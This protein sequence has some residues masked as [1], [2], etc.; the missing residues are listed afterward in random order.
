LRD[1]L[2]IEPNN[3]DALYYTGLVQ[4]ARKRPDLAT[5]PL[6][7]ARTLA[8]TDQSITYQLGLA[9][10][11]QERY[12]EAE[13]LLVAIFNANPRADGVGYYVGFMRYRKKNYQGALR[14][15]EAGAT[16]DPNIRQL[17]RF[18]SG[19]ALA[20]L[21]LPERAAAEV[22][23]ARGLLPA[24]P[25]TG[26]AERLRD[27]I[28]A[29]RE[30]ER[31]FHAELRLGFLYD[32]N[33]AVLPE[34]S[35]D[36]TA[37]ALRRRGRKTPGELASARFDYTWLREGP[38][39]LAAGYAFFQTINN[40][41][42]K[43]NVEN[44]LGSLTAGYRGT[45][46]AMPYQLGLGYT[47][48]ILFLDNDEFTQRHSPTASGTLVWDARH[49]SAALGRLQTKEFTHDRH[50]AQEEVRDAVN[51]LVGL[52]HFLR[53]AN[54]RH[55]VRGGYQLDWENADGRNFDYVG[56][57]LLVGGQYTLPWGETRLRYDYDVHFRNY[58]GPHTILP[59]AAPRTRERADTEQTHTFRIEQPLP[60]G[61]TLSA[62]WL[63]S[64]AR[65][66]L[67]IFSYNRNVYSLSLSWQY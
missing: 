20:V 12:D 5:E 9:Y 27:A 44:H 51:W 28:L 13:P 52:T 25:L 38:W 22:E 48:D 47:Y 3:V 8:P 57:R 61:L 24:S 50:I 31:R 41:E 11:V 40:D 65:S 21:G 18:Y 59:E 34:P 62:E 7:K 54:D 67:P 42:P 14:A 58:D 66:T 15:F 49:L 1:A 37:E 43:F 33:V 35:H 6:A 10:F 23:A 39:E 64:I 19:L 17:T 29:A 60:W 26:P 16:T 45:V 46:A 32:T 30:K 56:H 2:G 36:P 53:F 63:A 4:M 55:F